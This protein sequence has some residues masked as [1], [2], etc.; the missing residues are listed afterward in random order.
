[1]LPDP[2]KVE[3]WV[4][5]E[6]NK[7]LDPGMKIMS[8]ILSSQTWKTGLEREKYAPR[9]VKGRKTGLEREK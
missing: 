4:W 8:T 5:R 3:E 2:P 6:K 7:Q 9:P 1:M